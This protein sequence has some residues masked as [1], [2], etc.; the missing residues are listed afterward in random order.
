MTN[1]ELLESIIKTSGLKYNKIA[2]CLGISR[3]TLYNKVQNKVEF[4]ASEIYKLSSLLNIDIKD[5]PNIF[6]N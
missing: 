4:S 1:T 3:S 2:D 5:L 6:F